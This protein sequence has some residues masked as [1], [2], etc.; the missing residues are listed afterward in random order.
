MSTPSATAAG[1]VPAWLP[2]FLV[3]VAAAALWVLLPTAQDSSTGLPTGGSGEG[4]R[5]PAVEGGPR[6]G[7]Y[8][9]NAAVP[10]AQAA[11]EVGVVPP[12]R[13]YISSGATQGTIRGRVLL[14][15]GNDWPRTTTLVLTP[16]DED[17]VLELVSVGADQHDFRFRPVPFGSYRLR[18]EADGFQGYAVLLTLSDQTTDVYQQLVL[19]PDAR[20]YGT[21]RDAAG[22]PLVGLPVTVMAIT[23]PPRSGVPRSTRS[24]VEGAYEVRGLPPGD[25]E[26]FPGSYAY[27]LG[28]AQRIRITAGAREGWADLVAPTPGSAVITLLDEA[29]D[30][31]LAV[32]RV[33]ATMVT[34]G[35]AR[36]YS[37]STTAD[38][39]GIA[40]FPALPPGDY[41]FQAFGG[42]FRRTAQPAAV[43]AGRETRLEIPLQP[44][45][46]DGG[47]Q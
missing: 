13:A 17:R 27:P 34:T 22:A 39:E 32:V 18:V 11:V 33:E 9:P 25:Y 3:A 43:V 45:R 2:L 8:D 29:G 28:E 5:G 26:V 31:D 4:E 1:R 44:F 14:A 7:D 37:E 24:V 46:R 38:A 16:Q 35:N 6:P 12:D 19:E 21:V 15:P 47:G 36:G 20:V 30:N 42:P 10:E 23:E 40:R 41:R